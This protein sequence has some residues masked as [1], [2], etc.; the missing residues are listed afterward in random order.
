VQPDASAVWDRL[1]RR[2][3]H[4]AGRRVSLGSITKQPRLDFESRLLVTHRTSTKTR[5]RDPLVVNMHQTVNCTLAY[6]LW[7][8]TETCDNPPAYLIFH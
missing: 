5:E 3:S 2:H 7:R 4:S 6:V 1:S 8:K